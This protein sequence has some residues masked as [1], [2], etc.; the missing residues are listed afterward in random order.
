MAE[1]HEVDVA[2]VSVVI[3]PLNDAVA[4]CRSVIADGEVP[5]S[6]I[7]KHFRSEAAAAYAF[8]I[9]LQLRQA[10]FGF[11]AS[12]G[13]YVPEP[14]VR[15]EGAFVLMEDVP[16]RKGTTVAKKDRSSEPARLAA[17]TA[18][19]LHESG[20]R[21]RKANAGSRIDTSLDVD[22]AAP[23]PLVARF[24]A[25]VMGMRAKLATYA[26]YAIAPIHRDFHLGQLLIDDNDV[27]WLLD[28]ANVSEGDPAQDVANFLVSAYSRERRLK[29]LDDTLQVFTDEYARLGGEAV[30]QR[31]P[32]Y[33]ALAL[34]RRAAKRLKTQDVE[35]ATKLIDFAEARLEAV[36]ASAVAP[37][38][39]L[40]GA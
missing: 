22:D 5:G 34:L 27:V 40:A 26:P 19:K 21:V 4:R 16:G 30:V 3:E 9:L 8:Y 7:A 18:F 11:E 38:E 10:D 33:E 6:V 29:G 25:L 17:R 2:S 14:L 20:I 31:A 37:S 12:D 23:A 39:L 32:A 36:Q 24:Q 15:L 35:G 13:I 1:R 28:I